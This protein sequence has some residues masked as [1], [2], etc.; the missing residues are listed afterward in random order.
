VFVAMISL[1]MKSDKTTDDDDDLAYCDRGFPMSLLGDLVGSVLGV[2]VVRRRRTRAIT[3]NRRIASMPLGL[4]PSE[5]E[6]VS[7]R[8][9]C[10]MYMAC[11]RPIQC[12][13]PC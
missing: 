12:S 5:T 3:N 4:R 1:C 8:L 13:G 10:F 11:K 6:R 9:V 2:G 7:R